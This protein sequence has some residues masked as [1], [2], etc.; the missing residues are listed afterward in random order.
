MILFLDTSILFKLYF[1]EEDTDEIEKLVKSAETI[2]ISE[3]ANLEFRSALFRRVR[4]KAINK[5]T[6]LTVIDV[7]KKDRE[8]Y[9]WIPFTSLI[10][11]YS[12]EAIRKTWI[13]RFKNTRFHSIGKHY[14]SVLK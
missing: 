14:L 1:E 8:Q 10:I 9:L 6:A 7:Y 3:I 2:L 4:E 11:K 12:R 5:R 13:I